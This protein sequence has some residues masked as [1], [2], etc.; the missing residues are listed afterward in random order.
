MSP[1][2]AYSLGW[3]AGGRGGRH[4][5][6]SDLIRGLGDLLG[7]EGLDLDPQGGLGLDLPQDL[8]LGLRIDPAAPESLLVF[9]VLEPVG[10]LT[11]DAARALLERSLLGDQ[12][13]G[14]CLSLG[15]DPEGRDCLVLWRV[16]PVDL[17]DPST[18]ARELDRF[19]RAALSLRQERAPSGDVSAKTPG[20]GVGLDQ[21]HR[22]VLLGLRA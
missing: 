1:D 12:T 22:A 20:V 15:K 2:T 9:T 11:T 14:A 4:M 7:I 8:S 18:L 10:A 16:F 17:L 5:D 13:G 19:A 21:A 6:G 3:A